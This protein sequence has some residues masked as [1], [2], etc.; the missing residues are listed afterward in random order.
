MSPRRD[1]LPRRGR[2]RVRCSAARRA[3]HASRRKR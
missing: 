1:V 3:R 2:V